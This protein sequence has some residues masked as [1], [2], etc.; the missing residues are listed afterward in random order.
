[1]VLAPHPYHEFGSGARAELKMN[2]IEY[3]S[4]WRKN[5][6]EKVKKYT[7]T[8]KLKV[9]NERP[10]RRMEM[11]RQKRECAKKYRKKYPEK[12]REQQKKWW[13]NYKDKH[14]ELIKE[15]TRQRK[16]LTK[17]QRANRPKP[18]QCE[19][20]SNLGKIVFDHDH[21]TGKFRGWICQNCNLA[22][23]FSKDNP[24]TLI[25]L[26]NYLRKIGQIL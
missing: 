20:C 25:L 23:G 12:V 10:E 15:R 5:N 13:K 4:L 6:P 16:S 8:Y 21:K 1:M 14:S 26:A 7:K 24:E 11:L 9:K 2:N 18:E 3:I 17:I 19:V 22:L